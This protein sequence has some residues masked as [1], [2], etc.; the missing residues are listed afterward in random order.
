MK[1]EEKKIL[2]L[3]GVFPPLLGGPGKIVEGLS[4]GLVKQGYSVFVLTFGEDDKKER[5][6]RVK[7]INLALPKPVKLFLTLWH[8]LKNCKGDTVIYATD[9]YTSGFCA[10]IASKIT[11]KKLIIRF[12]GDS[13]W[14]SEYASGKT[15]SYITDFQKEKHSF[16]V[17]L[18]IARRNFI[19]KTAKK[20]ITDCEFLKS[21]VES[22][23]I[24]K[25]KITI[26]N[27]ASEY[28]QK[29]NFESQKTGNKILTIGR[30]VPW[31]GIDVL[32]KSMKDIKNKIPNAKLLIVGDGPETNNLK[33]LAKELNLSDSVEFLGTILEK[34]EKEK[35][36][37]QSDVFALNTFYEG[38][39]NV[40]LEAMSHALPVVTTKAGGNPEFVNQE[41]GI[42]VE[43]DNVKEIS[44]AI[45][46]L[47]ADKEYAQK[48][49]KTGKEKSEKYTWQSLVEKNIKLINELI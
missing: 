25:E 4:F 37:S 6:Y 1:T 18:K 22:F 19:L 10:A 24:E 45:I 38:M 35:I 46:K 9:N 5:P 42:L 30:L 28:Y 3:T 17:S 39:S 13:V 43:R 34:Q 26:I 47:L 49:G 7:R 14:E 29:N 41:N 48:L 44:E 20:I 33:N 23:G 8:A 36:Y 32:I 27:N 21:L 11:G 31:K 40:I 2:F 12:T 16:F 15:K